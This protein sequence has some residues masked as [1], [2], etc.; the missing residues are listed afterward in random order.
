M[1]QVQ[2][3]P[4]ERRGTTVVS[5]GGRPGG[6]LRERCEDLRVDD[7]LPETDPVSASPSF[8]SD[9]VRRQHSPQPRHVR[10]QAMRRRRRRAVPPDLIDQSFARYDLARREQQ[11]SEDGPLLAAAQLDAAFVDLGLER[12][13][14]AEPEWR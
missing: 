9:P 10:L 14:D 6:L 8:E 5:R 11:S 7:G 12:T 1:P 3:L 4:R 2:S 13:E